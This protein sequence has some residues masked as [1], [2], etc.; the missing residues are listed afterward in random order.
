MTSL[1]YFI[2]RIVALLMPF[3]Y[4]YEN[5]RLPQHWTTYIWRIH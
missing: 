2:C 4:L 1:R 5:M 3:N